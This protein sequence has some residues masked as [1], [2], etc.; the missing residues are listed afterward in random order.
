MSGNPIPPQWWTTDSMTVASAV[1]GMVQRLD[2]IQG[3]RREKNIRCARLYGNMDFVGGPY[4]MARTIMPQMPEDRVKI[5][6]VSSMTDTVTSKIAKMKPRVSFLTEGG[7]FGMGQNAQKLS[8]FVLGAFTT[9]GLYAEH[10]LAFRDSC[11][12]DIGAVKHAIVNGKIVSERVLATELMTDDMDSMYGRPRTLYQIKYIHKDV[13]KASFPKKKA[14]IAVAQPSLD[15]SALRVDGMDEY[16]VVIEAWHLASGPKMKDGRHVICLSN[17][18]LVDET[19][20]KDYFPFTFMRWSDRLT[21]FWGQSLA[22]R[23]IG[24]QLEINKLL[25]FIQ[26]SFH[27]GSAFKVFL[28]HGSRVAKEHINNDIGSIIYYTGAKPEYFTPKTVNNEIFQ[29]LQYLVK[30]AYEEAGVS[31]MSANSKKPDGLDSGKAIREYNNVESERFAIVSQMYEAT[32]LD[33]AKQYIDLTKELKEEHDINFQVTV[34][35]RKLMESIKW[36]DIDLD[37]DQYIMQMFP[38]SMLPHTPAGRMDFVQELINQQFIPR[39]FGLKLLDFPDLESYSNLANAPLDD[40]LDTI[41]QILVD[42]EYRPPEPFQDL[43]NGLKLFQAAYLRA[44]NQKIPEERL[45]LLRRWMSTAD[46]MVQ[47]AQPPPGALNAQ[48]LQ[49]PDQQQQQAAAGQAPPP[50]VPGS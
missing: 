8:K 13:L 31:Q 10:Q 17:D 7:N 42:G 28:E 20:T 40:I 38:V 11:V 3:G 49:Q 34:E 5:N 44:R 47:G 26:K 23:L 30:S 1:Y 9:N 39:E 24:T 21:G 18:W 2:N 29:H 37:H 14:S 22:E 27:L 16:A 4:S 36:S 48:P 50:P 12:F 15:T 46:S 43:Q 6:I 19:Y 25:R 32:F 35:T 45:E 41:D 33:A